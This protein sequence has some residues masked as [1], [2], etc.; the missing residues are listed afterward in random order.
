MP[1][2]AIPTSDPV[3]QLLIRCQ[4]PAPSLPFAP[5]HWENNESRLFKVTFGVSQL[6]SHGIAGLAFV[7]HLVLSHE[8]KFRTEG[9]SSSRSVLDLKLD[10]P[11]ADVER[12]LGFNEDDVTWQS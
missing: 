3:G 7:G 6:T 4:S 12:V 9:S 1:S 10:D 11:K 2:H 5:R 8:E